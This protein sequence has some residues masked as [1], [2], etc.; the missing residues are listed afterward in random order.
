MP[1]LL[2]QT[3]HFSIAV[4]LSASVLYRC[5]QFQQQSRSRLGILDRWG[6]EELQWQVWNGCVG[7]GFK[8]RFFGL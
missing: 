3:G 6:G 2:I 8:F 1:P 4:L 7:G 5:F